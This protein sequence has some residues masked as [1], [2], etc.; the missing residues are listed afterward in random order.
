[1]ERGRKLAGKLRGDRLRRV[2][3]VVAA[4]VVALIAWLL[5]GGG[6]SGGG[7]GGEVAANGKPQLASAAELRSLE[8]AVGHP[9]YWA[10]EQAG[11]RIELTRTSDGRI[12]VRYLT[13][14]APLGDPQPR[15]L[16]VGTYPISD[17]AAAVTSA[18][19][20]SGAKLRHVGGG[21]VAF[22]DPAHPSSVYLAYPG[23]NSEIEVFDPSPQR[24]L[25]LVLAGSIVPVG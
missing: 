19:G 14:N 5:L 24:A 10:G 13:A 8:G 7:N 15:F 4:L 22:I 25:G 1:M 17:A 18:A 20:R 23:S 2:S 16:T 6:D 9:V 12:Y 11:A 21:G 3:V